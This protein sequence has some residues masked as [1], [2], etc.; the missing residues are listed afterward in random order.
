MKGAVAESRF[1]HHSPD[2]IAVVGRV[3]LHVAVAEKRSS[4]HK[5]HCLVIVHTIPDEVA[6]FKGRTPFSSSK[7][8][9]SSHFNDSIVCSKIPREAAIFEDH[10]S[11]DNSSR[12]V[13]PGNVAIEKAAMECGAFLN[14]DATAF[15][16]G[17]VVRNSA[18]SE[19]CISDD[20][21]GTHYLSSSVV[22]QS[23]VLES[24]LPVHLD[25]A[26][27]DGGVIRNVAV[28]ETSIADGV[29]A[30]H[31][32]PGA[33][34]RDVAM[35]ESH[36][37]LIH[38]Y[39]PYCGSTVSAKLAVLKTGLA[40]RSLDDPRSH[41]RSVVVKFA[42]LCLHRSVLHV[43]SASNIGTVACKQRLAQE[44]RAAVP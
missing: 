44:K 22:L 2:S 34:V 10:I 16:F 27:V 39:C 15:R 29:D 23:A 21:D 31:T 33:V 24:G 26:H 6:G 28:V 40:L 1:A 41:P 5:E 12:R 35:T 4:L 13:P 42:S 9:V 14:R 7:G 43:Q 36:G 17:P 30:A 37:S 8:V 3:V 18:I 19:S 38:K 11:P 20:L 32:C 25:S